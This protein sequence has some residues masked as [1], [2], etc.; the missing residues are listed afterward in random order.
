MNPYEGYTLCEYVQH[1][2]VTLDETEGDA[3]DTS[4]A[5]DLLVKIRD[6][7]TMIR[8]GWGELEHY[9]GHAQEIIDLIG[10]WVPTRPNHS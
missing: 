9:K 4:A 10:E 5:I 1:V 3:A 6:E 2:A 8:S 7:A